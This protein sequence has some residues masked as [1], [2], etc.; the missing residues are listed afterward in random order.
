ML[1]ARVKPQLHGRWVS[2]KKLLSGAF[3]GVLKRLGWPGTGS[4]EA[5]NLLCSS[6]DLYGCG[7][8]SQPDL[9]WLDSWEPPEYLVTDP[10]AGSWAELR[11]L[12]SKQCGQP[13]RAW[14]TLLDT[15]G[16]NRV[17]WGEFLVAC[18]KLKF[19]GS[20]GGAWR[21]LDHDVDGV[22]TLREYD[23]ASAELLNSFKRFAED[24]F[25][26]V[27]LAFKAFDTDGSETLTYAELRRGCQR[28]HWQG[29]VRLLFNCLCVG[30]IGSESKRSLML[31]DVAFL[32]SWLEHYSPLEAA[33]RD[34]S[35]SSSPKAKQNSTLPGPPRFTAKRH[36]SRCTACT[37]GGEAGEAGGPAADAEEERDD[38]SEKQDASANDGAYGYGGYGFG[39]AYMNQSSSTTKF[40][41]LHRRYHC[42][43]MA[44]RHKTLL[45][46]KSGPLPWLDRILIE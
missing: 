19:R 3:A 21:C 13:L 42:V 44:P 34:E 9:W 7:F 32:D 41:T 24:N 31:Q 39:P 15:N 16:S 40:E 22:I 8:I 45:K 33:S 27:E 35:G 30:Q 17:C 10:D 11:D 46:A 26:S 6:L 18:R 36:D 23:A 4:V 25:G 20:P 28:L 5:D 12:M 14:R 38:E 1:A 43:K 29:E 2:D 37:K